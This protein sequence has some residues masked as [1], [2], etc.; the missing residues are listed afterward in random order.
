MGV[1]VL[2]E[3]RRRMCK[4]SGAQE[5]LADGRSRTAMTRVEWRGTHMEYATRGRF[6]GLGLKT[7]GWTG[8]R[9][10]AS[11]P[12]RRFRGGTDGKWWHRGVRV[13]AT[14]SHEGRGGRRMKTTSSWI[15]MPSD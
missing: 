9:V 5:D 6:D 14:L 2:T 8:L 13:K 1:T 15:I 4:S 10:W 7:I 3:S 12:G 11:K